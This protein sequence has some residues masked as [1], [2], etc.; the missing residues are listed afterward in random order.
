MQRLSPTI[1]IITLFLL[2]RIDAQAVTRP[3]TLV[4]PSGSLELKALLW[5]PEGKGP[6]PAILF[7]PGSGLHPQPEIIGPVFAKHG[8][9][10]FALFRS[11]QGL[12]ARQGSETSV[13][14]EAERSVKGDDAANVLQVKL[15]EGDQLDQELSGLK[16]LRSLSIVDPKRVAI[17]GHS[18]GGMLA[19][20]IGERDA[21]IRAIVNFGGGARSWPRSSYFRDRVTQAVSRLQTPIFSIYAAN[22][23]STDPG[24]VIDTE[25]ARQQKIHQLKISPPFGQSVSEG[26]SLVY[27]AI[28]TWTQEV[29]EFLDEHTKT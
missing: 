14:V 1:L 3:R 28:E 18:F 24:T 13:L 29:F 17:V 2:L 21:S 23:Y 8:Y 25:L 9:A 11:G 20:L 5:Q 19:M 15:L 16:K 6:F 12:S 27:L 7:C 22:D 26:H 10:F 4:I